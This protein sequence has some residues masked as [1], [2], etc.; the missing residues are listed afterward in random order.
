M[1]RTRF[2]V[3]Y[4]PVD[5]NEIRTRDVLAY[6]ADSAERWAEAHRGWVVLSVER[7]VR[8]SRPAPAHGGGYRI[9]A[10]ALREAQDVL[11]IKLPV[12]IVFSSR[13]GGTL[14]NHSFRPRSG[15]FKR[16]PDLDTASGG[17]Y[18]RIMLKTYLTAQRAGEVLWHELAHSMQ[19]ERETV[20]AQT[21]R[22]AFDSWSTCHARGKGIG[23]SRKPIEVEAREF[24]AWNTDLPLAR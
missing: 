3:T 17:M 20:G 12:K 11:G 4:S 9:D 14:G 8:R 16:N 13:N 18:H 23:Y 5:S 2:T 6:S 15:Q 21:M 22:E 19:A 24:E 10:A 7:H 1:R